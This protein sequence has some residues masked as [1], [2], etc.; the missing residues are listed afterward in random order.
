MHFIFWLCAFLL[1]Y[2]YFGYLL[3]LKIAIRVKNAKP[4]EIPFADDSTLPSVTVLLTVHN[5]EASI[6]T[7][8]D[9]LLAQDYPKN[10][11]KILV[12]SDGS[13]DGTEAIVEEYSKLHAVQLVVSQRLGKSGAQNEAFNHITSD[14]TLLTDAQTRFESHYTREMARAFCNQSV[15]CVTAHLLFESEPG[16]LAG[17]QGYYWSYELKLRQSES[18]LGWLAVASG[19]AMA[20]RTSL[21]VKL[22]NNVGDDC[23]MP[24]DVALQGYRVVHQPSAIAYD[25]MESE[26]GREFRTRIRMTARNWTGTWMRPAL[27]NPAT[28]PTY[29]LALWSHKLL[30]WLGSCLIVI[31]LILALILAFSLYLPAF[32]FI[33]FYVLAALGYAEEQKLIDAHIPLSGLACGFMVANTGFLLGLIKALRGKKI[34][35]YKAGH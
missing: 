21:F 28:H 13:T 11:F 27:L 15:G 30:R 19:Q 6:R 16:I 18:D 34:T 9:N 17:G 2:V 29:A 33:A 23:I 12:A 5:E 26:T 25:V 4:F 14:V 3:L 32:L 10:K 8:L 1:F 7:R 20:V 22:P 24:L 31:M 35:F